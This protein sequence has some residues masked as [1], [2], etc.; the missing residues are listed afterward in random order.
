MTDRKNAKSS[1]FIPR[2]QFANKVSHL[3][4]WPQ[5]IKMN[6]P[7]VKFTQE[8]EED[9]CIPRAFASVLHYT[10]FCT[11]ALKV[12]KNLTPENIV[13]VQRIQITRRFIHMHRRSFPIGCNAPLSI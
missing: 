11:V 7:K 12:K 3:H 2:P 6:A 8:H 9:L 13:I 4:K 10:G 5:L 1:K